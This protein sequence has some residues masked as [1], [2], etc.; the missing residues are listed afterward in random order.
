MAYNALYNKR[1]IMENTNEIKQR[2]Q[3]ISW[4]QAPKILE[5]AGILKDSKYY[6]LRLY[7]M[8]FV[9]YNELKLCYDIE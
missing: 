4:E 8:Q 2:L 6:S 3:K 7:E 5:V 1:K 9:I